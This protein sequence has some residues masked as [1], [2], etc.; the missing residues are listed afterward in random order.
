M[1]DLELTIVVFALRIWRHYLYGV[2]TQIFTD[3]KSFKYLM[4][5]N[6]LNIR[7]RR[8]I[9]LIKDYNCTIEYHPWKENMVADALGKPKLWKE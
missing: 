7:Q 3:H 8:W 2:W 5:Q 6:K 9:E 4:L 1:H